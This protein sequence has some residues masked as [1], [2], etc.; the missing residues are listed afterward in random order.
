MENCDFIPHKLYKSGVKSRFWSNMP[1]IIHD[2][3]ACVSKSS[4]LR[5]ERNLLEEERRLSATPKRERV[6]LFARGIAAFLPELESDIILASL[7]PK[8]MDGGTK[9]A[10][11]QT[12]CHIRCVC[13]GWKMFVEDR[14]EWQKGLLS[15]S[16]GEH[17]NWQELPVDYL[18]RLERRVPSESSPSENSTEDEGGVPAFFDNPEVGSSEADL[19]LSQ[20]EVESSQAEVESVSSEDETG[21]I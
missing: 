20:T 9:L 6:D 15:W 3:M 12:C 5:I 11:F 16:S 19:E 17:R 13:L 14:A 2:D 8:L 18:E 7:W 4:R 1:L 21:D 10:N